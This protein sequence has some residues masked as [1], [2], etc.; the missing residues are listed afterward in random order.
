MKL[1]PYIRGGL[2]LALLVAMTGLSSVKNVR[3]SE[4]DAINLAPEKSD[5][6]ELMV[7]TSEASTKIDDKDGLQ[8][9][10]DKP[11]KKLA[12]SDSL[13]SRESDLLEKSPGG[14]LPWLKTTASLFFV[15]GLMGVVSLGVKK[16]LPKLSA[17]RSGNTGLGATLSASLSQMT[18]MNFGNTALVRVVQKIPL[19]L[20]REVWVMDYEDQRLLVAIAGTSMQL[21]L[22]TPRQ[23][24]TYVQEETQV[25]EAV[26]PVAT[27]REVKKAVA[28]YQQEDVEAREQVSELFSSFIQ[29]TNPQQKTA[30][31][32]FSPSNLLNRTA[33]P[34]ANVNVAKEA[35]PVAKPTPR[36]GVAQHVRSYVS[37]MKPIH[38]QRTAPT[39][40]TPQ[41]EQDNDE[42][43][44]YIS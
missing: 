15:L 39:Q 8:F 30:K 43:G 3:A 42:F 36:A 14:E 33:K 7:A 25:P 23:T 35:A 26:A 29:Q 21:L 22:A 44:L 37:G 17:P 34:A 18:G 20:K 1:T 4:S 31:A 9:Y 16:F 2:A 32:P 5:L 10:S 27:K 41:I 40:G 38:S 13:I 19:G 12:A 6:L 28:A 24:Q 11:T